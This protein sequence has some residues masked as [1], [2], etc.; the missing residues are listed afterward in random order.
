MGLKELMS[1][2][3]TKGIDMSQWF[4]LRS[5]ELEEERFNSWQDNGK[6]CE[7]CI[8]ACGDTSMDN[9]PDKSSCL[10]YVYPKTKPDSVY[11]EGKPCKHRRTV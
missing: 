6:G 7:D 2:H 1:K 3:G 8:F 11:L 5:Q 4:S 9:S 10:I